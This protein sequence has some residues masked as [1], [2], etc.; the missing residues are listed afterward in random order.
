[1]SAGASG[2]I[3][4]VAGALVSYFAL[5][6]TPLDRALVNRNLKSLGFFIFY[7]LLYGI[8]GGVDNSAHFG[9][10]VAG[11]VLGA[12]IPPMVR[13]S[14]SSPY[15]PAGLPYLAHEAGEESHANRV[16]FAV[17]ALSAIVLILGFAVV[18]TKQIGIARYADA[19]KL[20]QAGRFD[21]AVTQLQ[22]P[23]VSSLGAYFPQAMLGELLLQQQ[24]PRAAVAPLERAATIYSGEWNTQ[25]NLALAYFG[26]GRTGDAVPLIDRALRLEQMPDWR[27]LYVRA[28]TEGAFG[29]SVSA[30]ADLRT[31]LTAKPDFA[32]AQRALTQLQSPDYPSARLQMEIPYDKLIMKSVEWPLYP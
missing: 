26:T 13:L 21:Q 30:A 12:A 17:A 14:A 29:D 15:L 16:A 32:E 19:V 22:Q 4:G 2:A 9:G 23:A 31:V 27:S 25:H 8:R 6:K 10:L 1:V 5:K 18:R 3:F 7:N 20:I 24:D 28:L 11:L